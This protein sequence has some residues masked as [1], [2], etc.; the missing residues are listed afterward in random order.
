MLYPGQKVECVSV[1]SPFTGRRSAFIERG[2]KYTVRR[3]YVSPSGLP[4]VNLMEAQGPLMRNG[5]ERGF[6]ASQFRP[7]NEKKKTDI[8]IFT[9][10]LTDTPAKVD[11]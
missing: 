7:L 10:M 6:H 5:A 4:I 2:R 9:K 3:V 11:A 8:S 1:L